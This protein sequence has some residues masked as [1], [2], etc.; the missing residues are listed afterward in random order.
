M[1]ER[2][3]G[4]GFDCSTCEKTLPSLST[5]MDPPQNPK[6]TS[7]MK[8][9]ASQSPMAEFPGR[10]GLLPPPGTFLAATFGGGAVGI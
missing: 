9:I 3:T 5:C 2:V 10:G 8:V 7:F 4:V 6:T 1:A